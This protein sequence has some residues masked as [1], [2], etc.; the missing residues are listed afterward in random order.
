MGSC[1][2]RAIFA[3]AQT[4]FFVQAL[5]GPPRSSGC[6]ACLH[7]GGGG[8][9]QAVSLRLFHQRGRYRALP[10]FHL[11]PPH[12]RG[13][14]RTG[15]GA[16]FRISSAGRRRLRR[17]IAEHLYRFRGIRADPEQIVVGAGS[18]YLTG[19]LI[20][21]LG[22]EGLYGVENPGYGKTHRILTSNG[23]G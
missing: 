11:G 12:A 2:P 4:R 21:L 20:Q 3:R 7:A 16:S 15:G 14:E 19:L 10:L 18:E 23:R 17:A 5:P 9:A 22:R 6:A 8:V 13:A 1:W